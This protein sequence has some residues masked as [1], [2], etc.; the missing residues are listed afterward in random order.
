MKRTLS[1]KDRWLRRT[2]RRSSVLLFISV[3]AGVILIACVNVKRVV[4]MPPHVPGAEFVGSENC[5][6]CHD[7]IAEDFD[8]STHALLKVQGANTE[9][10]GCESCHGAG[11][12][13]ANSGGAYNTIINPKKD[14]GVCFQ[15]HLDVR[16]SFH[17]PHAHPVL[18]GKVSCSDCHDPHKGPAVKGGT[19]LVGANDLCAQC[20][21]AQHGPFVFEHEATREGC[22]ICHQP[23][24]SINAKMMRERNAAACTKC[25]PVQQ[26]SGGVFIGG[27]PHD[28]FVPGG[29]S[30]LSRGTCWSA[31]CHEAVHGSQVS[32]SL[33]F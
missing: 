2:F 18:D 23:H 11:S 30:R 16:S 27:F 33:R 7:Q 25:H 14:P 9:H 6:E 20:H 21:M 10:I 19:T 13:H 17:L 12:V 29:T 4:V 24:G 5:S 22:T 28:T 26:T 8:S 31:G 3:L 32:S 15:C 1:F